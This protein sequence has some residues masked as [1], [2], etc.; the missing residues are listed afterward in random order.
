MTIKRKKPRAPFHAVLIFL[1]EFG[2]TVTFGGMAA[3]AGSTADNDV[4]LD[5]NDDGQVE[6]K[7]I[8]VEQ[9]FRTNK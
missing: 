4:N 8:L 6:F 9:Q 7:V 3:A 5:I 1:F 2:A